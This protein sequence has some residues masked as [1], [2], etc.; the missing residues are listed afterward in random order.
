MYSIRKTKTAS[1][2]TA[3]QV[4]KYVNR[5]RIVAVHIG[6]ARTTEDLKVLRQLA[7]DW[8][9]KTTKQK[10]LFA[11][12]GNLAPSFSLALVDKCEYLGIRY[13]FIYEILHKLLARFKFT[14]FGNQLLNDLVIMRIV[15]PTSKLKSLELLQEYFGISHRRQA[16]YEAVPH[17]SKLKGAAES[18]AVKLAVKEFAFNF[19]LVFYDVTTLYF[20]SFEPDDLR[21]QGFSKD[22]KSNQPQIVIGLVVSQDG[23]PVA[24]EIFAGNKFEGHT[25]IP[26]IKG[27]KQQHHIQSLTVVADAAMI[28]L[29]NVEALKEAK[30][31][32]IVGAR[33]ANLSPKLQTEISQKLN[34]KHGATV[35]IATAHGRLVCD[36]SQKRYNKDKREMNKQIKKAEGQLADP[37][38]IK[39][40]KFLKTGLTKYE[41]NS[42]LIEKTK[43][44][45]GIKGYYTNLTPEQATDQTIIDRY[46]NLW[47]VEQAF[48][49]AKS[50]L[51]MRPIFHFKGEIIKIHVLI[52]FM[53]LAVSKY[54]EIKTATSLQQIVKAFKQVTD[55]RLLNTLTNQEI[56]KRTK[57]P[58]TAK[59]LLQKLSLPH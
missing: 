27:F 12:S 10:P 17:F 31:N 59:S 13:T 1:G 53:A 6:S 28:S 3:V 23:F 18:L 55:A 43:L 11:Q 21:K 40:T 5:K 52:C 49:I 35:R 30:L 19:S 57:V 16:F 2:A 9:E 36:F 14:A 29:G 37:S 34:Q 20:E 26:V 47:H 44:L 42:K 56:I 25:L 39:R 51:A 15:E 48:R 54:M 22:N 32:Y 41:L 50:D 4:V 7:S 46:R 24:Y 38:A 58:D 33:I 8:I 45:L